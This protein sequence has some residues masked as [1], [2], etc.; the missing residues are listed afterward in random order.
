MAWV[1]AVVPL[2]VCGAELGRYDLR[3]GGEVKR[4]ETT[5]LPTTN[6]ASRAFIEP[7]MGLDLGLGWS[8]LSWDVGPRGYSDSVWSPEVSLF[9]GLDER[10]DIRATLKVFSADDEKD[11][12][13]GGMDA[14]RIGIGMR[15]WFAT[16]SDF[17]PYVSASLNHYLISMDEAS[18][19]EGMFGLSAE[20]GVAYA[21][22]EWTAVRLGL[23]GEFTLMDGTAEVASSDGSGVE[24]E[25]VSLSAVGF[26]IGVSVL[27]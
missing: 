11:G 24:E 2:T 4:V 9:Y 7:G 25:D 1:L 3:G 6:L 15:A 27:F 12:V 18:G 19:E 22:N 8:A 23:Q 10:F 26:G 21:F 20:A 5:V 17:V 16:Q 14:V 13:D